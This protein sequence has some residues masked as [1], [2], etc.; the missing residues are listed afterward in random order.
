MDEPKPKKLDRKIDYLYFI[1]SMGAAQINDFERAKKDFPLIKD[2]DKD[3]KFWYSYLFDRLIGDDIVY[4]SYLTVFENQRDPINLKKLDAKIFRYSQEPAALTYFARVN[5]LFSP[6]EKAI[7][8]YRGPAIEQEE[9]NH[10]LAM[11]AKQVYKDK[12]D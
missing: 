5:N 10:R 3:K 7:F 9:M 1:Y 2:E 12:N 11:W 8:C 4:A 6:V